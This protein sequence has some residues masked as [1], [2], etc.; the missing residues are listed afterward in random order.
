[1]IITVR[2][3]EPNLRRLLESLLMQEPPFEVLLVD[4]QSRDRTFAIAR[5]FAERYPGVVFAW[6]SPGS[7]G[8]G[9]NAAVARA[10]GEGLAFID[11]DCIADSAWLARIRQGLARSAV[12]A[13]RTVPMGSSAFG[14]LDRVELYQDGND[15]SYPSCNLG[16]RTELFRR[17]GGF[18]VRFITAEDIDLNLRAVRAGA[19]ILYDPKTIVLHRVRPTVLRFLY[20]AFWNGYGRKQLTEKH[21]TL[22]GHYRIRR[23]L[24]HQHSVLA[25][26]RM[27]AAL[28]GYLTRVATGGRRRLDRPFPSR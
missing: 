6:Q 22:W 23:L 4:A 11:G 9:R 16:Y 26:F 10:R 28:I 1:M 15:V 2:N 27:G 12:V 14:E 8:Q 25:V 20:Q 21:G 3:E 18:D 19:Q 17:L 5:E 13:G 7:R 24:K